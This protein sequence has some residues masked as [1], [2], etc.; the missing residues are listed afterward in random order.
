MQYIFNDK[1]LFE[2]LNLSIRDAIEYY[3]KYEKLFY[4]SITLFDDCFKF[5]SYLNLKKIKIIILTNNTLENSI[6]KL[7][8]LLLLDSKAL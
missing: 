2:N 4:N 1:D 6:K 8:S 7:I 3:N 5:L